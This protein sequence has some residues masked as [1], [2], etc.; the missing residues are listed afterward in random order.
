MV[1]PVLARMNRFAMAARVLVLP[2][3]VFVYCWFFGVFTALFK[4]E[5]QLGRLLAEILL[6]EACPKCG[7]W[8]ECCR[9]CKT[10]RPGGAAPCP[11]CGHQPN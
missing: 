4:R 3:A 6:Y 10:I 2:F 11:N 7:R 9:Q 5:F 1:I 8:V